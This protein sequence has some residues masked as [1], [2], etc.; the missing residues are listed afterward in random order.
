[1]RKCKMCRAN[2]DP[3]EKCSCELTN[4]GNELKNQI[5]EMV[6]CTNEK[7]MMKACLKWLEIYYTYKIKDITLLIDQGVRVDSLENTEHL[8][9]LAQQ[10]TNIHCAYPKVKKAFVK[11]EIFQEYTRLFEISRI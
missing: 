9:I 1:M 6:K 2:L 11:T 7:D 8:L 5:F 4:V 10:T 3:N